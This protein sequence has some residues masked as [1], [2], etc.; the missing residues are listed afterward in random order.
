MIVVHHQKH[1]MQP[2]S[3]FISIFSPSSSPFQFPLRSSFSPSLPLVMLSHVLFVSQLPHLQNDFI[4]TA[5]VDSRADNDATTN[6][7]D[8]G[9]ASPED[10]NFTSRAHLVSAI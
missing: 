6:F 3:C 9:S 2:W 7:C 5:W 10:D 8:S 1:S 4:P